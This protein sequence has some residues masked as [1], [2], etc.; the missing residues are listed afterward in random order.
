[1]EGKGQIM[2]EAVMVK[3]KYPNGGTKEELIPMADFVFLLQRELEKSAYWTKEEVKA[4]Q[5]KYP[6]GK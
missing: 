1:M 5:A 2:I 4:L 6:E 3:R